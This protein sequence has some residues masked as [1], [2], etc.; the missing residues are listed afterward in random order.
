MRGEG[1]ED[2]R[3]TYA[4]C[5]EVVHRGHVLR[6]GEDHV[7]VYTELRGEMSH[8]RWG[9]VPRYLCDS[10]CEQ[11]PLGLA[12]LGRHGY[13]DAPGAVD[14]GG[15]GN[16]DE[17]EA[18]GT[19]LELG[20]GFDHELESG[21][22][23]RGRGGGTDLGCPVYDPGGN[24]VIWG[25]AELELWELVVLAGGRCVEGGGIVADGC[26]G[27]PEDGDLE[28]VSG[29]GAGTGHAQGGRGWRCAWCRGLSGGSGGRVRP[30]R[31]G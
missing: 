18:D 29:G 20:G 19:A 12:N 26:G 10:L 1:G 2:E 7:A 24:F 9:V 23:R 14:G 4:G 13:R 28:R 31:G 3:K 8:T 27:E 17:V 22:G 6:G 16:D 30:R 5:E 11:T 15:C 25:E 21:S